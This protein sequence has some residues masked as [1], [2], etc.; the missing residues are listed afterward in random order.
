MSATVTTNATERRR[1][2]RPRRPGGPSPWHRM[3]G[4][5]PTVLSWA[6]TLIAVVCAL[7]A[8][9]LPLRD[10]TG[11]VAEVIEVVFIPA[12]AN[13][14]YAMFLAL[15]AGALAMRKRP[16]YRIAV[17]Y[18][19][20]VVIVDYAVLLGLYLVP[21][22]EHETRLLLW[23]IVPNAVIMTVL[24]V[25]LVLA[26]D[27]FRAKVQP[28]SMPK[29]LGVLVLG[30]GASALIGWG[31]VT[32][33]PGT[34]TDPTDRALWS[35][36]KTL[37]GAFQLTVGRPGHAPTWVNFTIGL[38]G[39]LSLLAALLVMFRSQRAKAE[40][41]PTDEAHVRRLLDAH[42]DR[43]SLGY[44][45]TRRDKSVVF[46]P[47]G[48]AA[49]T[50]RVVAG[51]S[52]A[53]ADPIGD[54]EAWGGAISAWLREAEAYAWTPAVTGAGEE[55][56]T[57]YARAGLKVLQL[58]DEAVLDV[59][60][61]TV[62]GRAMR[63]VRQ[64]ANRVERAGYTF[65]VRRHRDID[66]AEMERIIDRVDAWRDTET[67]RGFSMALGRLG[68]NADGR[69]VLAEAL[70][71][72]GEVAGLLSF[73]PWG[74]SGLS[75]D[76]M[77]RDR[78]ADNGLMEFMVA[79]LMRQAGRLGVQRVSLNFA[80]FRSVFEEGARLGAGPVLRAWRGLL[81]FLSRWWQL[82]ALYRSNVKYRPWWNPRYLCFGETRDLA[83]VALSAGIAEGFV[84]P[85]SLLSLFNRGDVHS[86]IA[87]ER[88]APAALPEQ[89]APVR[90]AA[91]Q[92]GQ[93][94]T[95]APAHG[96][97]PEQVRV[98]IAKADAMRAG[99]TDPYPVGFAPDRT[100]AELAAAHAG[101]AADTVTDD[102]ASIA[103]RVLLVRDHGGV[104]F[105]T[106][107]DWSGRLQVMLTEKATG[108]AGL[109]RWRREVDIGDLVGVTG[110]VATSRGGE[111]SVLAAEWT[112]TAKCL[113]PLPDKHLGI[114][115]P[116]TRVRRRYLDLAV[117][118]DARAL[119]R[120]R[121]AVVRSLR[122]SLAGR[123]FTEVETPILQ[124][125]H[126]G[127]NA[128]PFTTH[129][130]AYDMDLYLRIA[131][132]L[133][134]KRLCVGGM[135]RVFELGRTFRNEGVSVRHNPEFTMLEAYHA[136]ADYHDMR[137]LTQELVQTAAVAANGSAVIRRR[138][139]D[140][141]VEDVD[142]SG[143]WPAIPIN[144]AI[145][146]AVGAEVGP[147]VP[148]T[149]LE[150][151]ARGH[152]IALHPGWGHGEITLE[153]YERLVESVT[154]RPTF[155]L[156]FPT[157]VSPLTRQHRG[158]PRLA[159]KWDLVAYGTEL[160]TAY[161][162]LTDPVEQRRRL[163]EQSLAAAAGDP[164]AMELDEDFL[165]ALEYAMAPTG[166]LGIGVDRVVMLITGR[167]IRETL[168]FPLVKP[169]PR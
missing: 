43:D 115:D 86:S 101:T 153:L 37:G 97:L 6:L 139:D 168:P 121:S 58:G 89:D 4:R 81:L 48:K 60:T 146:D 56:A 87:A 32:M 135:D 129:I 102:T 29:A 12:P 11:R 80:V 140:G 75:L 104:C 69:C 150:R 166:G 15:L 84:T 31:L 2:G 149:E 125:V 112:M 67:E 103:G 130:N 143:E 116:E 128:R 63:V 160:G 9:F 137:R 5:I 24:L 42:G 14:A 25:V 44:F 82:E 45:A 95:R 145:S 10:A 163:T 142:V 165:T 133:F 51:V 155:Y 59:G 151:I 132:E 79:S 147:D 156:D 96:T 93:G 46:S 1:P 92:D 72:D 50:Y 157:S 117:S 85:P 105:A 53:S 122:E 162:E 19:A 164:E 8:L 88:S 21:A 144:T 73:V 70:G 3:R 13:L 71:P 27:E 62:E 127:A 90:G 113:R 57:A 114:G 158:D 64:A 91:P 131:P 17:A 107:Q 65:R 22:G 68:D 119:L 124:P 52:M 109:A 36:E 167:S 126:G 35:L 138:R 141:T 118:P 33:A 154:T 40:L 61:F 94:E 38:M 66:A 169:G 136:Y 23:L 83:R 47:S 26:R 98:R 110:P 55:G 41:S 111:L 28:A 30:L 120:A 159:E 152:G 16:A 134:L 148:V 74:P 99:G 54:P 123:G 78:A 20:L 76:L 108:A 7:R 39:A 161:T 18:T 34:L 100:C 77:R 49:V 106:V